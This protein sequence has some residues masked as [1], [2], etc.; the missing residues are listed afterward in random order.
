M[1]RDPYE[2]YDDM[3]A[4]SKEALNPMKSIG[5]I[6]AQMWRRKKHTFLKY[7]HRTNIIQLYTFAYDFLSQ[8]KHYKVLRAGSAHLIKL[9]NGELGFRS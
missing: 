4:R 1:K 2:I 3:G 5:Q 6:Q 9:T 7:L 8:Y